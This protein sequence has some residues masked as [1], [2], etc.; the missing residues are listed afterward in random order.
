MRRKA[1]ARYSPVQNRS[2]SSPHPSWP[3]ELREL[4]LSTRAQVGPRSN[5]TRKRSASGF[6]HTRQS[7]RQ[8][9]IPSAIAEV[10]SQIGSSVRRVMRGVRNG[11]SQGLKL[12]GAPSGG[13]RRIP[14][15]PIMNDSMPL[16]HARTNGSH[17]GEA[18]PANSRRLATRVVTTRFSNTPNLTKPTFAVH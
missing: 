16:S 1:S 8:S 13:T 14:S 11:V 6:G 7:S 2:P 17:S 18:I 9:E 12:F 15:N 4:S 5:T 3:G 10:T